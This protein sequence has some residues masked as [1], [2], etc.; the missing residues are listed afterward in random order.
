MMSLSPR[1]QLTEGAMCNDIAP[2]SRVVAS[3]PLEDAP[4]EDAKFRGDNAGTG[5]KINCST[6]NC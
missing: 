4:L 6:F 2:I 3:R 5:A 1:N